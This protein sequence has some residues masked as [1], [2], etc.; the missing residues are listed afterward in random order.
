MLGKGQIDKGFKILTEIQ[1]RIYP[2]II[3]YINIIQN[4]VNSGEGIDSDKFKD[5]NNQFFTMIPHMFKRKET[6]YM[7]INTN[8]I[9]PLIPS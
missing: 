2:F 4:L 7:M 1:V 6:A 3:I 8:N 5:L 9:Y